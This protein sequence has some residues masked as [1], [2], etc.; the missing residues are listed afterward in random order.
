MF[1]SRRTVLAGGA[2]T[3]ATF[4]GAV[5]G[6]RA[7]DVKVTDPRSV[8]MIV[9]RDSND[10]G[11][12]DLKT[13]K[14]VGRTFLGNNVN[15]HMVMMSPD[16]RYVVTGG[17]RANKAFV[18]D[19]RTLQLIKTIP[20]DLAPEHLAFSPDGRWYY[21]GNPDGD[22]I[23]VIDMQSLTRIKTIPGFVEPLNVTF[24]PDGAK[25]YVGNYGAH[26]VG[27]IDVRRHELLKKIQ[28]AAVP[29]VARLDPAKYLGEIKG[30]NIAALSNDGRYLYTADSDL[31]VVGVIDTR[32][33]R[34][35]ET[36]RVGLEPWRIYMSHDGRYGIT[37]NNGDETISIIDTRTNSVAA[38]LEAGP[39][40][41]GVNFA[42]GKAFVISSSSGFVYVYDMGSLRP[43]GRIRVGVNVQLETATT[44]A[45]DENIYL[46]E[47]TNH[48]VVIINAR[49]HAIERVRNV[50]LFPWG[51][52]IMDSKDNY[53]H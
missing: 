14:M 44:D 42:G 6:P 18:I 2:L 35:I 26:W 24:S 9:N 1:K 23:S 30:I 31:G 25:A 43:A 22:S 8:L 45:A 4:L 12:M 5:A 49:T 17:T 13:R 52:H 39:D 50:G 48:E 27:V 34:V 41:T 15:P 21:Q 36:I 28:V 20:V 46:A 38:T 51:T 7:Q 53:C 19:T 11:F 3:V 29:G 16:G 33:D 10:I 37:A 47:S 40:M 32:D